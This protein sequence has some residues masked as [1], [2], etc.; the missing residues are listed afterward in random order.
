MVETIGN[1]LTNMFWRRRMRTYLCF[2]FWSP[3]S[4]VCPLVLAKRM[5]E[6]MKRRY[7]QRS[8][9]CN[10]FIKPQSRSCLDV[11]SPLKYSPGWAWPCQKTSS[12][13]L[14]RCLSTNG[15]TNG[16]PIISLPQL[17][18]QRLTLTNVLDV[19]KF[20]TLLLL[21]W[22]IN[23]ARMFFFLVVREWIQHNLCK[24]RMYRLSS[25]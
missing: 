4:S 1:L 2:S 20:R 16:F 11:H 13:L 3:F 21:L 10:K 7:Y 19:H 18:N 22:W 17:R 6:W 14:E 24:I 25:R 8:G 5:N 12:L 23:S 15:A 9:S